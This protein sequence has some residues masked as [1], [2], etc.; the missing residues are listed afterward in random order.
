M[1]VI[2]FENCG[3]F[4]ECYKFFRMIFCCVVCLKGWLMRL[5]GFIVW[6]CVGLVNFIVGL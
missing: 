1:I 2:M 5:L 6:S 4:V 3:L